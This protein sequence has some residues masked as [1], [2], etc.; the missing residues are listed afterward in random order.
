MN[1]REIPWTDKYRSKT[2]SDIPMSDVSMS[3][4]KDIVK[5]MD[6]PNL[7]ITGSSG[8]CKTTT[9][10]CIADM[11]LG[12]YKNEY[13]M[14]LNASDDR[15]IKIV[16]DKMTYFCKK[17]IEFISGDTEKYAKH[18][19]ILL[20]EADGITVKAQRLI[21]NLME[22]YSNTRFAFTCNDSSKIIEGIQSR[23]VIFSYNRF[24]KKQMI[25]KLKHIC[26]IENVKYDDEGFESLLTI[27]QG[28]LRAA[29][30]N[31]QIVHFS[32]GYLNSKNLYNLLDKPHPIVLEN[33]F[34]LCNKKKYK[35][36]FTILYELKQNGYSNSDISLCMIE[37]L[38][39]MSNSVLGEDI[40]IKYIKE[41]GICTLNISRGITTFLQLSGCI[42]KLCIN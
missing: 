27:S 40:R 3:K 20:D 25:T 32:Y 5:N 36:V 11:L 4:I 21:K 19:I 18:K 31:L 13:V 12:E 22:Q 39:N 29:I 34:V 33:L 14:E 28:D 10:L 17:K 41:I 30:N 26:E 16:Q 1:N 23:C 15:G 7:I 2:I 24:E 6:M 42:A 37:T 8:T 38:K 9:I 35:E